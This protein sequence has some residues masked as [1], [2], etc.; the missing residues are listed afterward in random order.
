MNSG[1]PMAAT[2]TSAPRTTA[3]MSRV[4]EWQTVTVASIF[5]R[6]AAT[7]MPT[8]FDRPTTT[9]ALPRHST[10]DRVS[11]SAHPAGV[12]ATADGSSPP[13]RHR[14]PTFSAAKPSASLSTEIRFSTAASLTCDGSGS[15]TRMPWIF[16]SAF[17]RMTASEIS[18][19]D[20]SAGRLTSTL[21]KPTS[22]AAFFFMRTYV[23]LSLRSPTS[24]TAR[25]GRAPPRAAAM[26]STLALI[27]PRICAEMALPSMTSASVVVV[28][29]LAAAAVRGDAAAAAVGLSAWR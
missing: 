1:L 6:S 16:G 17:N 22:A 9:A 12:H 27:S 20:A 4:R 25:P 19:S 15:C 2:T 8:M 10:P 29:E 26:A 24:T 13:R 14:L 11:S 23:A 28:V 18:F 21:W 5:C 7:G 3:A